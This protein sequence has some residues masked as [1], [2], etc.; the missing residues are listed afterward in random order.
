MVYGLFQ[1]KRENDIMS[2]DTKKIL[3]EI[4]CVIV[5]NILNIWKREVL[6]KAR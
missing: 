5:R 6:K 4:I 1:L 3:V 2:R